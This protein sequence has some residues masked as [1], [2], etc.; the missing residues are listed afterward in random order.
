LSGQDA[1][2]GAYDQPANDITA[3]ISDSEGERKE[4][5]KTELKPIQH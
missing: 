2:T 3:A 1:K 4:N 5:A